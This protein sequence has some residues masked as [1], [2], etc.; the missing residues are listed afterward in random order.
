MA[1]HGKARTRQSIDLGNAAA[2]VE[3]PAAAVAVEVMVM[4]LPRPFIH[5][6]GA[7]HFYR[8][9]PAFL[10]E[11]LDVPVDRGEADA[12]DLDLCRFQH[13]VRGKWAIGL[14]ESSTNGRSLPGIALIRSSLYHPLMIA[15]SQ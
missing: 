13:L 14:L 5:R 15:R 3:H 9:Q 1:S 2:Q 6:P 7:W 12:I 11:G 8:N 10:E 4:S